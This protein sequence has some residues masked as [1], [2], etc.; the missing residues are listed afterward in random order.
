MDRSSYV[1]TT[2]KFQCVWN[3]EAAPQ[4]QCTNHRASSLHGRYGHSE[5]ERREIND[6]ITIINPLRLQRYA[7]SMSDCLF[8]FGKYSTSDFF[9]GFGEYPTSDCFFGD[10]CFAFR[11]T[12]EDLR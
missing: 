2:R 7:Y 5:R 12:F 6:A 1:H 3:V 11:Y 4:S 9:F 8:G 10:M